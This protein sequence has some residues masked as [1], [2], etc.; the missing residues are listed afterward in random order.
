MDV[1]SLKEYLL[2]T[3]ETF[4]G[5]TNIKWTGEGS[6]SPPLPLVTLRIGTLNKATF[7]FDEGFNEDGQFIEYYNA[8]TM[9]E[10]KGYTK[11]SVGNVEE[12]MIRSADN[13][14]MNDL[15]QFAAYI[16]SQKV[17]DQLKKENISMTQ[18]GPVRDT[19]ISISGSRHEYSAMVEFRVNFILDSI[20]ATTL[21]ENTLI[22][23][24]PELEDIG[25]FETVSNI[26][27]ETE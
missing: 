1:N 14:A 9:L 18:E 19:T 17:V 13:T 21:S 3:C 25:Y 15:Q 10:V 8:D 6:E 20:D 16:V 2:S 7:P 24:P 22:K 26:E 23:T 27:G 5:G 4:F 12:G 11:G